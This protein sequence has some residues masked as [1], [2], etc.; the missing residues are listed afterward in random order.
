MN[1]QKLAAILKKLVRPMYLIWFG[2]TFLKGKFPGSRP[3]F[4]GW[5]IV[6]LIVFLIQIILNKR[7]HPWK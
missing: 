6:M 7:G 4:L 1:E 2:L 3:I 5:T